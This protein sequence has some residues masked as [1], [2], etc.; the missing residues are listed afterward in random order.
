MSVRTTEEWSKLWL[1]SETFELKVT[2]E[3]QNK[4]LVLQ[5]V[6]MNIIDKYEKT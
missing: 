6:E 2:R 4:G 1:L 3:T 5:Y